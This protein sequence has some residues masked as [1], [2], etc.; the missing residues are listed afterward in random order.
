M[1]KTIL[2]S[3]FALLA[4]SASAQQDPVVMTVNGVDV[5]RSEFEY[6]FNKNNSDGVIDKK[7]VD[8][9]VDLFVNYKLKVAAAMD[10]KLDTLSSFKQEFAMYRDQQV[11][12]TLVTDAEVLAEARKAYDRTK[13]AIGPRGL[14][15]PAHIFLRLSTKATA[16][17]QEK[18]RQRADSV[19]R[20]LKAGA[21]FAELAGKV[22]QMSRTASRGGTIGWMQPN[23]TYP[24]FEDAAYALQPGEFSQPVLT[25]DGYHIIL[26]K[27]RKQLEPFEQLKDMIVR[28]FEQ[29]G[30]R[31]AIADQKVGQLVDDSQGKLTKDQLMSKRADSL[32][33]VDPEARYLIQEYHDG[34]LH[35][36][37]SNR[38]VWERAAKDEAGL[39]AWFDTHKKNYSW[40]EPHYKGIAYHVKD[41]ADVKA[42]KKCLK[43]LPFEQWAEVLRTTFNPDTIVRIR[44]EK[45]L[46]KPGDNGTID[47]MVFKIRNTKTDAANANYP[48][49]AVYGK[50]LK[51][52]PEDYTDVRSQVVADYQ[53]YLEKEWIASLRRRYPVKINKEVLKTVNQH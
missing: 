18:V 6:S 24:E 51:K 8:E 2:C 50:K 48:I 5:P 41:K 33:A 36:E 12:P 43:G 26:M 37:I 35:Y 32:A 7:S 25:P 13:E 23:Q 38:Q 46:F 16:Q 15:L 28:S 34:L 9:Y 19:W 21:D 4:V 45:G 42:V 29:Q 44:V 39:K 27:E 31:N 11:R 3:A 49:E 40:S 10:E 22:S 52:R 17:E 53:D 1:R 30:I 14:I 20:A 47:R